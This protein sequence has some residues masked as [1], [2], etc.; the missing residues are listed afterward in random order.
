MPDIE[1]QVAASAGDCD[2]N[3]GPETWSAERGSIVLCRNEGVGNRGG[4]GFRFPAVAIPQGA[5]ITSA[6]LSFHND[7]SA[8]ILD[9]ARAYISAELADNAAVFSTQGDFDTRRTNVT[10][11]VDWT[12]AQWIDGNAWY[13]SPSVVAPVQSIINRAGWVTGNALVMFV[14]DFDGRSSALAVRSAVAYDDTPSQA[15]KLYATY[16]VGAARGSSILVAAE[17]I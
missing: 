5:T 11:K 12:I 9:T 3:P 14:E 6:R 2:Y 15:A 10:S 4:A 1:A 13:D 7:G 8:H 17:V 16:T